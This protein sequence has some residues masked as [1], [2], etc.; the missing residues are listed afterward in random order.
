MDYNLSNNVTFIEFC[1]GLLHCDIQMSE[2]DARS[3]FKEL[4]VEGKGALHWDSLEYSLKTP[5]SS[6]RS[7]ARESPYQRI[8][9]RRMSEVKNQNHNEKIDGAPPG[10]ISKGKTLVKQR[11][12]TYS[13]GE[14]TKKEVTKMLRKQW[15]LLKPQND[16]TV[17][18]LE[19]GENELLLMR[20]VIKM[21]IL[22][23]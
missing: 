2:R 7:I 20:D 5:L 23:V 1:T 13:G 18:Q 21:Y 6:P 16:A 12:T 8:R 10:L 4:D 11:R 14:L 3:I 17:Q 9:Y 15:N 22:Q 19:E